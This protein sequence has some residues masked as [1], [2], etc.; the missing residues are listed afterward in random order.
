MNEVSQVE[1]CLFL[2]LKYGFLSGMINMC[3]FMLDCGKYQDLVGLSMVFGEI[4]NTNDG[5]TKLARL[6]MT[7]RG[8]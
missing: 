6:H 2:K 1:R 4:V 7:S 3:V 5:S 8:Y